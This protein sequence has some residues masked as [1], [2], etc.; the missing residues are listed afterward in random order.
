MKKIKKHRIILALVFFYSSISHRECPSQFYADHLRTNAMHHVRVI[1]RFLERNPISLKFEF[2][3]RTIRVGDFT[4]L[5]LRRTSRRRVVAV[6]TASIF[7]PWN[8]Y[9]SFYEF[10]IP[11]LQKRQSCLTRWSFLRELISSF[12][13]TFRQRPDFTEPGLPHGIANT[14]YKSCWSWA[15]RFGVPQ[16]RALV[17]ILMLTI[18]EKDSLVCLSLKSNCKPP[19]ARMI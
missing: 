17:V 13:A 3:A 16:S 2:H 9:I 11:T 12:S 8:A 19:F 15:C 5:L 10:C 7:E 4:R 6:M 1:C 14:K 18:A